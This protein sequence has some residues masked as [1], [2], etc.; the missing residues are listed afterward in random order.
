MPRPVPTKVMHFT[1]IANLPTIVA[2]G[3][4]SDTLAQG[5]GDLQVEIGEPS[6][7]GP[8]R[9]R[10]VTVAP[11]GVVA[12][13]VPFYF[14]PY[15]P[16]MDAIH[17]GRVA[18]YQGGCSPLVYLVTTVEQ[19]LSVGLSVVVSDRNARLEVAKFEAVVGNAWGQA[20]DWPLMASQYWGPTPDEPDRKE[21]RMAEC[22]VHE[23]VPWS[24]FTEVMTSD[25]EYQDRA[26]RIITESGART[27][28]DVRLD[29]YTYGAWDMK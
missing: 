13:F 2:K 11:G 9:A 18:Q 20:I 21:R 28:V 23:R 15:S 8:R 3:L 19:L 26:A 25:A 27:P 22:L 16:M 6:I 24:A 14:A 5:S 17:H 29:W 7:K 1:H 12:D 4:V 10:S